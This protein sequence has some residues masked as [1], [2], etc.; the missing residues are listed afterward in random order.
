M[1]PGPSAGQDVPAYP[2]D[3]LSKHADNKRHLKYVFMS[4]T[5]ARIL[6]LIR[7]IINNITV[8]G[9]AFHLN[10]CMLSV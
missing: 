10:S 1:P 9:C 6:T 7:L 5:V 4:A 3:Q 8:G 2:A